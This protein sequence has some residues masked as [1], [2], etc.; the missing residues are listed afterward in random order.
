MIGLT[1]RLG[2]GAD[3]VGRVYDLERMLYAQYGQP[4][5][6]QDMLELFAMWNHA[7]KSVLLD[8][9]IDLFIKRAWYENC[10]SF[11]P[12]DFRKF[13]APIIS[14]DIELLDEWRVL[15]GV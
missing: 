7:R 12:H 6:F 8:V 15:S 1:S 11:S 2:G 3:L 10:D 13:Q 14:Q 5:F 9:G 4:D